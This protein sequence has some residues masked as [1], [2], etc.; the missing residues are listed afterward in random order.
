MKKKMFKDSELK[1]P[2]ENF[3]GEQNK[4]S[5]TGIILG[6]L[7]IAL[8]VI[9]GGLYMWSQMLQ[10]QVQNSEVT[11]TR[12]TA[13]ENQEPESNNAKAD[14]ETMQAM[15]TSDEIDAIQADIDSTNLDQIDADLPAIDAAISASSTQ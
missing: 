1:M 10:K 6:L 2:E 11:A 13:A 5:Y 4:T 7:I 15:S 14:T 9:L 3:R 8:V 12:P